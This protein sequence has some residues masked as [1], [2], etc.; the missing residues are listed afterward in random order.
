MSQALPF[1]LASPGLV[2]IPAIA[3][4]QQA[5]SAAEAAAALNPPPAQSYSQGQLDQMLAPVALYPDQVLMQVLMAATF[6]QQVID[7]GQWLQDQNNAQLHG[8]ALAAALA[9]LPWD[10]SVKSLVAFPQIIVMMNAH[11][12][13]AQSLGVAF[14]GQQVTVMAEVQTLRNR[15]ATAGQFHSNGQ[16]RYVHT[17]G[18]WVIEPV[19][20]G[21]IYIP[22]YNPAVVY[23]HW[24]YPD[25]PPIYVPPPPGFVAAGFNLGP[26]IAFS[27][28]FGVV[29]PLWGW[30]H[31]DWHRHE[32]VINQAQY[33]RITATSHFSANHVAIQG[34]AWH[35]TAPVATVAAPQRAA[36]A[37]GPHPEGTAAPS[38]IHAPPA[39]PGGAE[40][41]RATPAQGAPANEA[42]PAPGTPPRPGEPPHPEAAPAR[43]GE[44]AHP[45]HPGPEAAPARPGQPAH[46]GSE[47]ARPGEPPHPGPEGARP[48]EPPHAAPEAAHPGAPPHGAPEAAHPAEPA[49]PAGA[50]H[51][52]E[53]AAPPHPVEAPH[54]APEAAHPA[55]P[56]RPAEAPHPAAPPHPAEAPH[57]AA[58]PPHPAAPPPAAH[59]APPPHPAPA[60]PEEKPEEPPK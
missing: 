46:P 53:H 4:A 1:L 27:V 24:A 51:P 3:Y 60:K 26:G 49:H 39:R 56:P 17:G 5:P 55:E 58:P 6:P 28:G 31:P 52:E 25:Y 36:P 29:A 45:G 11:M 19:N 40:E 13:W 32:F 20:P 59:P 38:A 34:G 47:G 43:P 12:D 30:G 10:P 37:A 16:I 41:H 57:P 7:A 14:A 22:I 35:R 54:P 2:A 18:Y 8:A 23:G 9:P 44:P 50:P 21:E 33:T 48:G 15:A 42:H